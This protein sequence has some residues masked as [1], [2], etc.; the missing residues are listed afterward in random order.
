M[1]T[2]RSEL[3]GGVELHLLFGGCLRR[4]YSHSNG[5]AP[6]LFLPRQL[7]FPERGPVSQ[8]HTPPP[9]QPGSERGRDGGRSLVV[10]LYSLTVS[11]TLSGR[12]RERERRR[13]KG[14]ASEAEETANGWATRNRASERER[15][16]VCAQS[17]GDAES[18]QAHLNNRARHTAD[19]RQL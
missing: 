5:A 2:L 15:V 1:R 14:G 10:E 18:L 8:P 17:S 9:R 19:R 3:G 11:A 16:S 12:A 4:S 13:E 6:S 7:S